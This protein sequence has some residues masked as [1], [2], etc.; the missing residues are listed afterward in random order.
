MCSEPHIPRQASPSLS[1]NVRRHKQPPPRSSVVAARMEQ[2]TSSCLPTAQSH[3]PDMLIRPRLTDHFGIHKSQAELDFAIQFLNE[4]I[5]LYLDPFLLWK[6]PSQQDQALHTSITNSFNNLNYL[7]K[8]GAENKAA[9]VLVTLSECSEVGLG[10]SKSRRGD[11]ISNDQALEV[12][13]LFKDIPEYSQYGFTHFEL[14]QLYVAGISKDRIS[15][16]AC[17]YV[18]SFLVDYTIEQCEELGIPLQTVTLPTLY[19][20]RTSAFDQ[21]A[22][23]RLP[24]NPV[25]GGPLIFTP[26][27][28]L[29]FSPWINFDDYFKTACPRDE[30][31]NP[32]EPVDRVKVLKYNRDNYDAVERY[33]DI[34]HKEAADCRNDPLFRQ[35]P[36]LSARRK[37]ND[38]LKLKSGKGDNADTQYEAL[39]TNL[40][41]TLLYPNLDFAQAQSRTESG[42]HVRDLIF[43]NNR[44]IDFLDEIFSDYGN[45]QLVFEMKNVAK[46]DRD[47]INQLTRYL[48]DGIG[49]FGTFLTRNELPRAMFSNTIDLWSSQRKC[50]IALTDSDLKLM[51]DVYESKQRT[52]IEV[53]KKKYIEFRRSCPS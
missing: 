35:I 4:D 18:K 47:H 38:L 39:C 22:K 7:V 33:I 45:R 9:A 20:Y 37:L 50:I 12:L 49:K 27:R 23:V 17:N 2:Q 41:A 30:I 11:R 43:Y 24:V 44:S 46:I 36:V 29:R 51:V 8:K 6:S 14:I 28:W 3:R 19:N 34:K 52:P 16:I 48:Q 25:D 15:D 10:V 32:D 53:L 26:K 1:F 42:R 21:T 40:L 31:F 13:Q 5:P